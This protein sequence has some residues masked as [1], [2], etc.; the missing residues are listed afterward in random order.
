MNTYSEGHLP[1]S[2]DRPLKEGLAV[3]AA[4]PL[5]DPARVH[6]RWPLSVFKGEN[7]PQ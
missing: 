3:D 4:D 6:P 1:A 7:W 2:V 5:H